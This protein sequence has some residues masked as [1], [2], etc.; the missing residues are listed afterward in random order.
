MGTRPSA[1]KTLVA[2]P[3]LFQSG[4]MTLSAKMAYLIMR[5]ECTIV[6]DIHSNEVNCNGVSVAHFFMFCKTPVYSLIAY[7]TLN[8]C[9]SYQVFDY[10]YASILLHIHNHYLT[11]V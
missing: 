9:I 4:H 5:E 1:L 7:D 2:F 8:T 3:A 6:E 10:T 11:I